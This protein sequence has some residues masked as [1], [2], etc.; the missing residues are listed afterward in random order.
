LRKSNPTNDIK[1]IGW[2]NDEQTRCSPLPLE[3]KDA[4]EIIVKEN[5]SIY[6]YD[7]P[8]FA[9][10]PSLKEKFF[11]DSPL[12]LDQLEQHSLERYVSTVLSLLLT[13][14]C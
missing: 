11:R 3:S 14:L 5:E 2:V 6:G 13:V 4:K 10:A 9:Y 1:L 8:V 12:A 7:I